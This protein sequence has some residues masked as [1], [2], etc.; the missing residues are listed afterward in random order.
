MILS[1]IL[2][3]KRSS[4]GTFK[5]CIKHNFPAV[6]DY[7][8]SIVNQY[9]SGWFTCC[10]IISNKNVSPGNVSVRG[11]GFVLDVNILTVICYGTVSSF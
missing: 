9:I 2:H 1:M 11:D 7:A 3:F 6:K 4:G 8:G 5:T 10:Y